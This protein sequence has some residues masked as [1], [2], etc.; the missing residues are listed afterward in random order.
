MTAGTYVKLGQCTALASFLF[1]T[2]ILVLFYFTYWDAL[3]L[4]GYGF[5]AFTAFINLIVLIALVIK[6]FSD[7]QNR[8]KLLMT[9]G[10]MLLNVPIM[11]G[12]LWIMVVLLNTIRITFVNSTQTPLTNVK[13]IGCEGGNIEQLAVGES[14]TVWVGIPSDCGISIEYLTDGKQK[15][16]TVAGY[17]TPLGGRKADYKIGGKNNAIF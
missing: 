3:F 6:C 4:L 17:L 12:Y 13:I 2:L 10:V 7:K 1:G 11:L 8:K 15:K 9:G 14:E 5:I 16:E